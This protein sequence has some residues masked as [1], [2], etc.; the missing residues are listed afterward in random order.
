MVFWK[1]E[2]SLERGAKGQKVRSGMYGLGGGLSRSGQVSRSYWTGGRSLV[3][4]VRFGMYGLGGG[5]SR[6]VL[7]R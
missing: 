2:D 3:G 5:L 1:K 4:Q 7:D 6:S